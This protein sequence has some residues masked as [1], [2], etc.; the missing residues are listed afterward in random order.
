MAHLAGLTPL[1]NGCNHGCKHGRVSR[2]CPR[3]VV[4][5]DQAREWNFFGLNETLLGPT[6]SVTLLCAKYSPNISYTAFAEMVSTSTNPIT[7]H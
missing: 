5:G 2:L 4:A 7:L 6:A 1:I 3:I